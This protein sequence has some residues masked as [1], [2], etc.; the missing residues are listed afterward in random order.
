MSVY[1]PKK[2]SLR[3]KPLPSSIPLIIPTS[4]M[5]NKEKNCLSKYQPRRND[6]NIQ[7]VDEAVQLIR[8]I[9]K[10]I[11][12]LSICGPYRTGKSYLLSRILR[13][14]NTFKSENTMDPYTKGVWMSTTVL[15]CESFIVIVLDTE[16]TD[17]V[18]SSEDE[19]DGMCMEQLL[20]VIMISS[21]LIY[22][23]LQ[24]PD[25]SDLDDLG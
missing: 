24:V 19:D 15:E 23:S 16:G 10:P 14:P 7:L 8:T 12:I 13:I 18:H 11:A 21:L 20:V 1:K 6:N 25:W 5:W 9:D 2:L 22:N 4:C 3:G 17:S